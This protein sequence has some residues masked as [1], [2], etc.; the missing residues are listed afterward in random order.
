MAQKVDNKYHATYDMRLTNLIELSGEMYDLY[1][2]DRHNGAFL[3][4]EVT[5]VII[6]CKKE[7]KK[8]FLF[9]EHLHNITE[10]LQAKGQYKLAYVDISL[11]PELQ[12]S[13]DVRTEPHVFVIDGQNG[14][15]Y[16]WD[17]FLH[18][19]T[20]EDWILNKDYKNSTLK[21]RA[22]ARKSMAQ[23][24]V[25]H[26]FHFWKFTYMLNIGV[27]LEMFF[28]NYLPFLFDKA[29]FTYIFNHDGMDQ[30]G[31]KH[32]TQFRVFLVFLI[33][34]LLTTTLCCT[35]ICRKCFCQ[36]TKYVLRKGKKNQ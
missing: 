10:S 32:D 28:A 20:I 19:E 26:D 33:C 16:S 3:G 6:F 18:P 1:I 12:A 7:D 22:P 8:S 27:Y 29:P 36:R 2:V 13:F 23:M 31:L 4:I 15:T 34:T 25:H 21:F 9:A 30:F 24:K 14:H 35:K 5:W 11:D 17:F